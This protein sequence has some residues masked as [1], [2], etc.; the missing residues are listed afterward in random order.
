MRL[1]ELRARFPACVAVAYCDLSNGMVLCASS[2][3]KLLQ[4]QVDQ[5][6]FSAAELL[7][8]HEF[9]TE[10]VQ[11]AILVQGAFISLILRSTGQ[12]TEALYC[13]CV[14][15]VDLPDFSQAAD[16]VLTQIS[17]CPA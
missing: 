11:S 4:E 14:F 5:M 3:Q 17:A 16:R 2:Q 6:G 10:P 9:L 1:N 13:D 8:S 7:N 12:P 15:D